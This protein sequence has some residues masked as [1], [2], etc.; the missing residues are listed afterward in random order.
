MRYLIKLF[1]L[2]IIAGILY[3]YICSGNIPIEYKG[4]VLQVYILGL[5]VGA[6]GYNLK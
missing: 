5:I 2:S 3:A 1:A 6:I 4:T